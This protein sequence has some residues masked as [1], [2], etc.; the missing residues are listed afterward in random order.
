M[1]WHCVNDC[2]VARISI[3]KKDGHA[4]GILLGTKSQVF[5]IQN[6]SMLLRFRGT[7][8]PPE[9]YVYS[10]GILIIMKLQLRGYRTDE[11]ADKKLPWESLFY[12]DNLY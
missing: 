7:M 1:Y 5:L 12:Q 4:I 9:L 11:F 10:V 3:V 8:G 6:W 2:R